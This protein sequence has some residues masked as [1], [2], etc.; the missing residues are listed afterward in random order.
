VG[1]LAAVFVA[2][3]QGG[4]LVD[5]FFA[6]VA[7]AFGG[8]VGAATGGCLVALADEGPRAL[9]AH[10]AAR[11]VPPVLAEVMWVALASA[12][13]AAV[14]A[15]AGGLLGLC[16]PRARSLLALAATPR[17]WLAGKA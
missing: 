8:L 15:V 13:W 16:G 5:L 17:S 9:L 3:R 2:R 6:A 14:G 1:A 12:C 7:G 10:L 11:D 4:K